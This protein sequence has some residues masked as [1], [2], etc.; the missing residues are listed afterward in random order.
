M[1]I[2]LIVTV[3]LLSTNICAAEIAQIKSV[4]FLQ[5]GEVSKLIVDFEGSVFAKRNHLKSDKQI[6]LDI[7]NA[8]SDARFMR[9]IDTSEFSGAAVFVSPYKK[10]GSKNDLRF[11]IQL[12]DNV[13]SF[14]ENKGSRIILHIENRFGVFTKAKLKQVEDGNFALNKFSQNEKVSVPKSNSLEDILDNLSQSGVK[15]YVGRKISINVNEIK[16]TDILKMIG[17]T[18]GFNIIIGDEVNQLKPVTITLTNLPWDE[19][20][21]TMLNLGGLVARKFGNIL[22]I[23]TKAKA[24]AERKKELE[25][26]STDK[27]LEP[28][29]TKIFPISFATLSDIEKVLKDYLSKDRGTIISDSRTQN[30]IV[31][32]TV[33]AIEKIKKVVEVL[34]TQTPLVLI[35]SKIVEVEESYEFKA[36][37]T[38][39][40]GLGYNPL[41]DLNSLSDQD[42]S[43]SLNTAT[44]PDSALFDATINIGRLTNLAFSLELMESESKGKIITSP[45][46]ITENNKSASIESSENRYFNTVSSGATTDGGG[47]T[48]LETI[49][50]SISLT[51]TPKVTNEGSIL[52]NVSVS[53]SGFGIVQAAGQLPPTSSK[54]VNTNVLVGNGSTI[55]I[56]GMFSTNDSE[57]ETGLPFFKDLPLVGWLFKNAYNPVKLRK[58]LIIFL[59]PRVVNQEEAGLVDRELGDT[60]GI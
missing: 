56:G 28:L 37:L 50:A 58:E 57:V 54:S 45:R 38:R 53:K 27:V 12:R 59:T 10:P 15:R 44:T 18:S 24:I 60:L 16:Y 26:K 5:E 7:S 34:D 25:N 41:G 52:M 17:S 14:V 11:A 19:V 23:T 42:G 20:L 22:T 31:R 3:L 39:G 9:G 30:L 36:G 6:I 51:V 32:D 33:D 29:V 55:V 4:N 8:K 43:F 40:I 13:R 47:S 21:D 46:I 2:K 35:E 1:S 49:S 48:Q